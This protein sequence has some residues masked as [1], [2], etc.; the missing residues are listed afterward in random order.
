MKNLFYLIILG[1]FAILSCQKASSV[2]AVTEDEIQIS[3]NTACGWCAPGD[4]MTITKATTAYKY[5][6]SSCSIDGELISSGTQQEQWRNLVQLLDL[7]K[8]NSINL[9]EC[10]IC[11]DG[12]DEWITIKQNRYE[13]TIRYGSIQNEKL[14]EIKPFIEKLHAIRAEMKEQVVD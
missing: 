11:V 8:F 7:E 9:N 3:I 10:N 6:P 2:H 1:S 14:K 5:R 13:H 12:C 4:S